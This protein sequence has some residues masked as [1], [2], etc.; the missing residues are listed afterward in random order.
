MNTSMI[1]RRT[2][3]GSSTKFIHL[4]L[5]VAASFYLMPFLVHTLGTEQYGIWVLASAFAGYYGFFDF[6]VST[7]TGRFIASAMGK[8]D[9][10]EVNILS[11]S[12]LATYLVL[13]FIIMVV[14]IL[15]TVF[16]DN[17]VETENNIFSALVLVLGFGLAIQFPARSFGTI[18]VGSLRHDILNSIEIVTL[19]FRTL[20]ILYFISNGHGIL[21]LAVITTGTAVLTCAINLFFVRKVFPEYNIRIAYVKKDKIKEILKYAKTMF[22]FTMAYHAKVR[23]L[24]FIVSSVVSVHALVAYNIAATFMNYFKEIITATTGMSY[25]ITSRLEGS[26]G[27]DSIRRLFVYATSIATVIATYITTSIIMYGDTFITIWMGEDFII[28][29]T[30]LTI[31]ASVEAIV[32]MMDPSLNAFAGIS[33]HKINA[34]LNTLDT[35]I[36]LILA[37]V[38]GYYYGLIGI[39]VGVSVPLIIKIVTIPYYT[40]K[41]L[42]VRFADVYLKNMLPLCIGTALSI[43]MFYYTMNLIHKPATYFDL[44]AFNMLQPLVVFPI[45]YMLLPIK[46]KQIIK[47]NVLSRLTLKRRVIA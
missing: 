24:P 41:I 42:E 38:L 34:I 10:K 12:A 47:R 7:A 8:S 13:S 33:K 1:L 14:T 29:Y 28:S 26:A 2:I 32:F 5:A 15:T 22:V 31:V 16:I 18:L 43:V 20:L 35:S 27:K 11:S 39:A 37:A 21:A 17:I 36:S 44:I 25:H 3:F 45:V 6:G 9:S 4:I 19:L 23:T 46:L 30:L 40:V